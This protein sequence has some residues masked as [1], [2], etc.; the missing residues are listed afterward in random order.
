MF[1]GRTKK[2]LN[3]VKIFSARRE[4][5]AGDGDLRVPADGAVCEAGA[6]PALHPHAGPVRG[7]HVHGRQHAE[8]DAVHRP[9]VPG[10]DAGEAPARLPLPAPRPP[11]EGAPVHGHPGGLPGSPLDHQVHPRLPHLPAHGTNLCYINFIFKQQI[12]SGVSFGWLQEGDGLLPLGVQP[13]GA[14]LAGQPHARQHQE[15]EQGE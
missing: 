3:R 2:Y 14:V 5:A 11:E 8:G 12:F 10:V 9:H 6:H 15:G 7:P 4:G 13:E 1:E